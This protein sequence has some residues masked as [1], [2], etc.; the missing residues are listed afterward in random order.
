M[1]LLERIQR[2][3]TKMIQGIE[4][5]PYEDRP[6]ELRLFILEKRRHR[7][8]L[9]VAFQCLKGSNRKE[10]DRLFSR[11]VMTE[12]GEMVSSSKRRD[13]DWI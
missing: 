10:G 8:D 2:R 4:H 1:D 5:L 7:D 9:I 3:A 11:A 12:Q 6:R 13:L